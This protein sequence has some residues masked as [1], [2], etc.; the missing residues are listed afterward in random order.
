MGSGSGTLNPWLL[1]C[2]CG[3]S[4]ATQRSADWPSL[5]ATPD[6]VLLPQQALHWV[7]GSPRVLVTI[8]HPPGM[9]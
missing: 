8:D 9:V 7:L 4:T 3:K 5:P 2:G 1:A 6:W